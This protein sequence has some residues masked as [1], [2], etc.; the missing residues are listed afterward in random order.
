MTAKFI[1]INTL[2]QGEVEVQYENGFNMF[3]S[4]RKLEGVGS[5]CF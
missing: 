3:L 1:N 2:I 4:K 5:L